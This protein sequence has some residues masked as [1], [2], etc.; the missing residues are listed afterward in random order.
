MEFSE[1]VLEL[2]LPQNFCHTDAQTD[3]HFPEIVKSCP[4]H[5]KTCKS[6]K[7]QKSKMLTKPILSSIYAEES[8]KN[9]FPE[10]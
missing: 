7:I 10:A 8:K 5:H 6:I 4:G 9:K 1:L 2:N 3:K